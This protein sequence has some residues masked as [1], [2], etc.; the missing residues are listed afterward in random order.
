MEQHGGAGPDWAMALEHSGLGDFLRQ[1][2]WLYPACNVLHVLAVV[3][4]VGSIVA[5]DLR[6][7]GVGRWLPVRGLA[8][9]LLPLSAGGF[10]AAVG[11]GVL[12]FTADATAVWNNPVFVYKLSLIGLGLVNIAA[13]HIGPLRTVDEWGVD[14]PV[15][16]AAAAGAVVSIAGWTAT[17][18]LGRLI[19]YF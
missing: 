18:T 1:S 8:R 12:L 6:V 7:L 10:V 15:P 3:I 4:M 2:L 16:G 9:L 19:A 11:S 14:G 13:F 17:A 5:F